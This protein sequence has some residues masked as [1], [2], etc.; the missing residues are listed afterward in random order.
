MAIGGNT[1]Y[2]ADDALPPMVRRAVDLA[3][4]HGD[5]TQLREHGPFDLLVLDGGGKG[6]DRTVDTPLD[7]ADGWLALGGT[8]VLDD[9]TPAAVPGALEHDVVRQH[10]LRHP[11]LHA[12]EIRLAPDLATI[13]GVRWR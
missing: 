10:W 3:V 8:I 5:W 1:A 7:P 12:T 4:L 2:G 6:K 9:F 13:I 11:A